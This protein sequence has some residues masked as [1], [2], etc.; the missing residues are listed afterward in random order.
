[1]IRSPDRS[2]VGV[3]LPHGYRFCV[4]FF[5]ALQAGATVVPLDV[6]WPLARLAYIIDIC[7]I[8][9]L[10]T[11]NE[12]ANVARRLENVTG[13][14]LVDNP[15]QPT[16]EQLRKPAW[17]VARGNLAKYAY[18]VFTSGTTGR[19]KGVPISHD[20]LIPLLSWQREA[21]GLGPH[22]RSIQ[23]LSVTFDFGIE[24][25]LNQLC[26]GG[27]LV[28]PSE[29]ERLTPEKYAQAMTKYGATM[30]YTTPTFL[31]QL[32]PHA[33]FSG[34]E[35]VL[36]G[37][38]ALDL[39][40]A[41]A[42]LQAVP[43]QARVFNGYGPTEAT[44]TATV[45]RV[46]GRERKSYPM[47]RTI[48]I[49]RPCAANRVY[50]LD[51]H[52]RPVP[53]GVVGE[54]YI[55]GPGVA[56]GYLG[57]SGREAARFER[58]LLCP[59]ARESELLFRTGDRARYLRDGSIE[60]LGRDDRQ[61]KIRGH[62]IELDEI[63]TVLASYPNVKEVFVD[64]ECD[65]LGYS[66][67]VAY[68]ALAGTSSCMV[69]LQN[70][71]E[72]I[73]P[74]YMIPRLRVVPAIPLNDNGKADVVELRRLAS[75]AVTAVNHEMKSNDVVAVILDVWRQLL[76]RRDLSADD[77]VFE[78]GAHSLNVGAAHSLIRTRTAADFPLIRLFECYTARKLG[79]SLQLAKNTVSVET[80]SRGAMRRHFL[81]RVGMMR[82]DK[83]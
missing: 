16:F 50:V 38:E 24:E 41:D 13:L 45:H 12:Y 26:F 29:D 10:I 46:S 4:A 73:L 59:L 51:Q 55:G 20:N 68:C 42:L 62:R 11:T 44:I 21:F 80:E 36:V 47:A 19:P 7:G 72:K 34:L 2:A 43:L 78:F 28:I 83:S 17:N 14:V 5:G 71:L 67:L 31:R 63:A 64:V 79:E 66:R 61:V 25:V 70:A 6:R 3:L 57:A 1:M 49:G 8:T 54:I 76:E 35:L 56:D 75:E 9:A 32:L 69:A 15:A 23:F 53:V 30:L 60:F 58:D 48:P 22:L 77:N 40:V 74:I 37:G 52:H 18:I 65:T 82:N 33:T 81:A 39:A 27:T